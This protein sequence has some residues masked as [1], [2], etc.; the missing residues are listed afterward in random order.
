D[1]KFALCQL[2]ARKGSRLETCHMLPNRD[3]MSV[4]AGG[5]MN[6]SV[7]HRPMVIGRV[8]AW[9]KYRFDRLLDHEG[10]SNSKPLRKLSRRERPSTSLALVAAS[11]AAA[12]GNG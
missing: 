6:D 12:P 9:L 1:V 11:T 5:S 7:D 4:S 3:R 10:R 2:L 8:R